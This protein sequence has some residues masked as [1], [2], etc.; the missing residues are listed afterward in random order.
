MLWQRKRIKRVRL[1]S[2][3]VLPEYQKWGLGLVVT[4]HLVP[5]GLEF[6]LTEAEFSFVLESNHLSRKTLER[7]GVDRTNSYR[8]YDFEPTGGA[9]SET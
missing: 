7:G 6:G 9:G 5:K 8:I 3:N 2:T 1:V 4:A